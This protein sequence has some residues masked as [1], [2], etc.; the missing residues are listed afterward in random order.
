MSV[1]EAHRQVTRQ[2]ILDAV[3]DLVSEGR[4]DALSVPDVSRRSG[5]SLATIYRYFPTKDALLD[6][7]A[8]EPSRQAAG[9]PV[10]EAIGDGDEF[11]RTMWRSFVAN[12]PL[13]RRQATSEAGREMRNRRYAATRAWMEREAA[14]RGIDPTSPEGQRLVRLAAMLTSSLAFLDLHDRQ[15]LSPDAAADDV[16]WAVAALYRATREESS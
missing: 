10:G 14:N 13:V 12:L 4:T 9:F 6:A 8:E 11:L 5:V 7:A 16:E 15:G 3:L 1:R 2:R